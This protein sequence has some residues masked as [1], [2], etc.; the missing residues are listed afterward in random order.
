MQHP[1]TLLLPDLSLEPLRVLAL[2]QGGFGSVYIV[3]DSRHTIYAL[4]TQ[5]EDLG[6]D[7]AGL[8]GEAIKSARITPHPNLLSPLG[9]STY[10]K[11]TYIIMP[12][13]K[14]SLRSFMVDTITSEQITEALRQIADGLHHLHARCGLLHLDLKPE[15]VLLDDKGSFL[16]SDFGLTEALPSP[17][18]LQKKYSIS[19]SP[20]A[21]TVAYMSPEHF[22]TRKLSEKSDMFSFGIIMYEL[23]TGRYPFQKDSLRMLANS[24]LTSKPDFTVGERLRISKG[25]KSICRACLSKS[26]SDR[27]AAAEILA[28]LGSKNI[29]HHKRSIPSDEHDI[30][31]AQIQADAGNFLTAQQLLIKVLVNNPFHFFALSLYAQLAFKAGEYELASDYADKALTAAVW[32]EHPSS[33]LEQT[34][35]SLSYYY[36]TIDPKKSIHYANEAI[37]LDPNDWQALGNLAEACRVFGSARSMNDLLQTGFEACSKAMLLCP[38]DLKLKVTYGGLLL[39]L[40]DFKRLNPLVVELANNHANEDVHVRFLLIRTLIATGQHSEADRWLDPMR[41]YPEL[42]PMIQQAEREKEDFANRP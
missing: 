39:A 5:R 22:T 7:R 15:N 6:A 2:H 23:L 36:L 19:Q 18:E 42:E 28:A 32:S 38:S 1:D 14:C 31:I 29:I 30:T 11:K 17:S 25:L 12:A 20:L 34:L 26:P 21:G 13:L 16:L 8:Y 41:M 9:I 10:E 3:E 37:R 27:P 4:K 33:N 40:R 35:H 24:I